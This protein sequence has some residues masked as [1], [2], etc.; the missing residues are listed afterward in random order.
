[1]RK[2]LQQ[3]LKLLS[4]AILKKYHPKIVA[5]TGSVGKSSAKEAV[6]LVLEHKFPGKIRHSEDNLN[7]EIGLPLA[8]VGGENAKRNTAMWFRNFLG[9]LKQIIV[10]NTS[11]PEILILEMAADR[12]GDIKYLTSFAPPDV[13]VVTAVGE[14]PVHL[15]FFPERDEYVSEK[16]N[17]LKN[18]KPRG[19]AV[20]NYDDLSVRELRNM[21]PT[22]R[23][24]LYYGFQQGAEVEIT[25]FSY[26][27]PENSKDIERSGMEFSVQIRTLSESDS[28]DFK[29][30]GSLGLPVIYAAAAGIAVGH[31]FDISL[32][33]AAQALS[34][35]KPPSHRLEL[36]NGVKE[37]IIIDDSYNSSPLAC[38]AALNLLFKFKKNR[39]LAVLGS[40]RELGINTE[41]AHR[42]IGETAAKK[43]QVVFCVGDEMVFAREELGKKK[44]ILGRN[45]FWHSTSLE[46]AKA[47]K[48]FLQPGDVVLIKGSRSVKMESVVEEIKS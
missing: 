38:E 7:T 13:A 23:R 39:R 41:K 10:K 9:A 34:K 6:Y 14:M 5:I 47:V 3:I 32:A 33:D 21:V 1:M 29:I 44:F 2:I 8:I 27:V 36:L 15:E 18:L 26:N 11:Y 16:A 12:P 45:L 20:L 4:I 48:K 22:D 25:D 46:A 24:R 19:A 37:S 43:A 35:F 40:M 28:A 31:L 42:I 17:V 30:N